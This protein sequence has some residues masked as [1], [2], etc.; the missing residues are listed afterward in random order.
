[1]TGA[2]K[3]FG[4]IAEIKLGLG[5]I[6]DVLR[7]IGEHRGLFLGTLATGLG[8][9][10]LFFFWFPMVTDDSR[11][12]MD[13]ATNWLKHGVYGQTQEVASANPRSARETPKTKI[14]PIDSRLPGYPGFLAG[15]FWLFG[16]GN[17]RAVLVT[18]ILVDLAT[19]VIIADLARRLVS[20]RAG[21]AAFLLAALCPFLAN[22]TAAVLTETCEIFF[23]AL[24][25]DCAI[26]ALD[27][28]G[29]LGQVDRTGGMLWAGTGV[30]IG[31]CILLRPDGGILLASVLLYL[32]YL[33]MAKTSASAFTAATLLGGVVLAVMAPWTMRNFKIMHH[34]QPLA[35][36]YANESDELVPRGFNRWV[37]TWMIDYASVEEI[38]WNV[39]GDK[40]DA[41]KL[42]S[43]AF[44]NPPQKEATLA[45]IEDYNDPQDLTPEL[46][47][48][49]GE[50]ATARIRAHPVRYFVVLPV[51]RVAD[52]W[53][54]PRTEI[55]PP[56][57]RWWE[58]DDDWKR[59]AVAVG[60]GLLNLAYMVA[61]LWAAFW[62]RAAMRWMGLLVF[63][64][65]L[66]SALLLTLENPEPRYTLEGYPAVLVLAASLTRD[67]PA[68]PSRF[69]LR[70]PS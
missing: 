24:A 33:G 18:Q 39:P 28:M 64:L 35:P 21:Q 27:R 11:V 47:T 67:R 20:D 14:V 29:L 53:L 55:L 2:G 56:D 52:M 68:D 19:C 38:Y 5:Y 25:L 66:R 48:R 58:F 1:V 41:T 42:P 8:L 44:D 60:F 26:G 36:R 62:R 63:F 45:V 4:R 49:F 6:S 70:D 54:R 32:L 40:I 10:L 15:I 31:G 16:V 12:Y 23:T 61:A 51:L 9:R 57:V 46:D 69:S 34:F 17:I 65:L 43:R 22:Y 7:L 3:Q 37:K 59:S 30:A 13:L 50:I